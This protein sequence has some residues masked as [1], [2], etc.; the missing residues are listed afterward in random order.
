MVSDKDF[1]YIAT[2]LNSNT[3]EIPITFYMNQTTQP[4][5]TISIST[6]FKM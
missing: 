4:S 5:V 2:M 1:P 3:K 6:T